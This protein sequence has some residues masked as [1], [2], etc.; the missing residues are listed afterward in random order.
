MIKVK[1][2]ECKKDIYIY[3]Y[4][5][6]ITKDF[7]CTKC[8]NRQEKLLNNEYIKK[9]YLLGL[10]SEK[11]G[12]KLNVSSETILRK[13][14]K[15][16][17]KRRKTSEWIKGELHHQY[18]YLI[19]NN[20]IKDMYCN[21]KISSEKIAY[22]LK[23]SPE[24]IIDRLR[25]MNIKIRNISESR[26]LAFTKEERKNLSK[27]NIKKG[28]KPPIFTGHT[29]KTK[30]KMSIRYKKLWQNKEY[31]EKTLKAMI[32][33]LI[34]RPTSLEQ[35]M[36]DIIKKHNLPYR[37]TGNGSFLIGFKN[38]DFVNVNG[39][40]KLIEVG[41]IYHHKLRFGSV[42][43]YINQRKEYYKSYGWKSY[44]FIKDDIDENEIIKELVNSKVIE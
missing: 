31:R 43:N 21:Q 1:C 17:I 37:Y 44:F 32:K 39:E 42:E 36:I 34:K 9:S 5:I 8:W 2:F 19:N 26:K 33:G 41:N 16:N 13:L 40:K 20:E 23:V 10:S 4:R 11:I 12:R 14:K 30:E 24:M 28:Y 18:N 6:K 7:H 29:I 3:P 27:R 35:Q 25:N 22:K 15:M 38:P